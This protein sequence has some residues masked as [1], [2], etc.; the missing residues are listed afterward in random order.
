MPEKSHGGD[1]RAMA[2][3]L[4]PSREQNELFAS[5]VAMWR[6]AYDATVSMVHRED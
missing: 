6:A 4:T 5:E 1:A 3:I 2:S